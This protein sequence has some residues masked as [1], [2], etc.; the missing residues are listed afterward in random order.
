M[1]CLNIKKRRIYGIISAVLMLAAAAAVFAFGAPLSV[2]AAEII[3]NGDYVFRVLDDGKSAEVIQYNGKSLYVSVPTTVDK[4]K[5]ARVGTAAFMSNKTIKELEV[6]GSVEII[7]SNAFAGC[8]SLKKIEIKGSVETVGEC[9]FINCSSLE[10]VVIREGVLEISDSAFSGCK[11]LK[12]IELPESIIRIGKFAF[13][14][15]GS[16][17]TIK[18]P[19]TIK[20]LGGYA[21]EGTKWM[22]DQKSDFVTIANGILIKYRGK[23]K[24]RSIPESVKQI[25]DCA[26]AGDTDITT[27]LLPNTITKIGQSAFEGCSSLSEVT[28]PPSVTSVGSRAFYGCTSL[29]SVELPSKLR[30]LPER[31]F[32]G[33]EGL[34]GITIHGNIEVVGDHAFEHCKGLRSLKL[35]NGIITVCE[36]AF[37]GCTSLGRVV[38]PESVREVQT[39]AFKDCIS[40]TRVEFNGDTELATSAFFLCSN[41]SEIV[42]Y[43]T[44]SNI[45]EY[46]FSGT[47][48]ITIYSDQ[49]VYIEDFARRIKA[50]SEN[51]KN[52]PP[53]EDKGIAEKPS[54]EEEGSFSGTYTFIVIMIVLVDVGLIVVFS[55]YLL[56]FS[57]KR[58]KK[59][60]S[61]SHSAAV[62]GRDILSE[63]SGRP[64]YR[65]RGQ[66]GRPKNRPKN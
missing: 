35:Q 33:C 26:F 5:V 44:P 57:S 36:G 27:V 21:F 14:N 31:V 12:S 34:A 16:L 8:T 43:R 29:V 28:L 24:A 54:D 32:S 30:E 56:F 9:A 11:L 49:G 55:L 64:A 41:L 39:L 48:D 45:S 62:R 17:E 60:K 20:E 15:C 3:D 52:L 63:N 1:L 53:Y 46:A 42:F 25:G 6:P 38:V 65:E 13:L 19:L 7:G 40:L 23:E 18:L 59:R 47:Q 50:N 51:I 66:D 2:S 61:P 58:R 4:Y 10:S 37:E 22:K